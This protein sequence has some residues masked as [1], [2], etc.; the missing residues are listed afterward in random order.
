MKYRTKRYRAGQ[1]DCVLFCTSVR[2]RQT[3]SPRNGF[4]LIELLVVISIISLLVSI[5]L[6]SLTK[7]KELAK[8]A[9]C[10]NNLH[11]LGLSFAM[12]ANECDNV[13]APAFQMPGYSKF[14]PDWVLGREAWRNTSNTP[15]TQCP[16]IEPPS[17]YP[18]IRI[19]YGYDYLWKG[20]YV[21][22]AYPGVFITSKYEAAVFPATCPMLSCAGFYLVWPTL[23]GFTNNGVYMPQYPHNSAAN[24]LYVDGHVESQDKYN[25][26]ELDI[27]P[28]QPQKWRLDPANQKSND[29]RWKKYLDTGSL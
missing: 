12:Y 10:A 26:E 21:D 4:T 17:D 27:Y 5:L 13:F 19:T 3:E 22:T 11:Q 18:D 6:P 23:S 25:L 24:A 20:W 1:N 16:C 8:E 29:Y 2:E 9:V 7:A 28:Q 15:M 14:W